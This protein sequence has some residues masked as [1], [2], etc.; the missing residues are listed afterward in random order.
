M[1]GGNP[2]VIVPVLVDLYRE[3]RLPLDEISTRF[4]LSELDA[5]YAAARAGRVVKPVLI[6]RR[7]EDDPAA[8]RL[9]PLHG[10]VAS[11]PPR[12]TDGQYFASAPP[13]TVMLLPVI[14]REPSEARNTS[15]RT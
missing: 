13:S 10:S 8:E 6:P 3:G 4:A 12:G 15:G 9:G 2:Q 14:S 1:G 7:S 11:W 5:A